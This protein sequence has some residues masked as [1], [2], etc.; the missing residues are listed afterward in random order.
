M[1]Y[2]DK[3]LEIDPNYSKALINKGIALASLGKI[4]QSLKS[5]DRAIKIDSNNPK[6]WYNKG[7]VLLKANRP[8]EA[9]L[10]AE[11]ALSIDPCYTEARRL[12][13]ITCTTN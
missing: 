5:F 9:Y 7:V 12:K 8:K 1:K 2:L 4:D 10:C 3:A 6:A 11:K 13:E